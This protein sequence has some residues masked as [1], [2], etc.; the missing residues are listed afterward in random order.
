MMPGIVG[1]HSI[2]GSSARAVAGGTPPTYRNNGGLDDNG[3]SNANID[4]PYPAGLQAND[5]A[6]IQAIYIPGIGGA[7]I[8]TPAGW[9]LVSHDNIDFV[10]YKHA[11]YWKRLD[12]S[13]TGTVTVTT[14][15]GVA[16]P[17][18]DF[19]GVM[20]VWR[21]CVASG[22]PYEGLANNNATSASMIGSSVTTSA[23]NETILNFCA[24]DT[25]S[26]SSPAASWTEQYDL[27]SI[28]GVSDGG[29]KVYSIEKA[30][31]GAL[32]GVTHSLAGS[33]RWQVKSLALIPA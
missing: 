5:I 10:S 31:A 12:G 1:L 23:N 27:I 16:S 22:T 24:T 3:T 14:S 33:S 30:S 2:I 20:S 29:L 26:A 21:G 4:V 32:A 6:F 8:S 11:V 9:T 7:T 18:D 15:A 25:N 19:A 28:S 13:E 17:N